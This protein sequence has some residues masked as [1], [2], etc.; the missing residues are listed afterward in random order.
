MFEWLNSNQPPLCFHCGRPIPTALAL[1]QTHCGALE[2]KQA[3]QQTSMAQAQQELLFDYQQTVKVIV[4]D[5]AKDLQIPSSDIATVET[6]ATDAPLTTLPKQRVKDIADH[7]TTLATKVFNQEP[8]DE[9]LFEPPFKTENPEALKEIAPHACTKC[10][11]Y[12]CL[13]AGNY[14][15]F[16]QQSTIQRAIENRKLHSPAKVTELYLSF[17]PAKTIQDGCVFQAENGCQLESDLRANICHQYFCEPLADFS[18]RSNDYQAVALIATDK[19]RVLGHAEI[20]NT[21][22]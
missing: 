7:I 13:Q 18:T 19:N 2:C 12:C 9:D 5:F 22:A 20:Q 8:N 1:A 10:R 17:I 14:N 16:I 4:E 3:W 11:G 15:S 6:P 21:K